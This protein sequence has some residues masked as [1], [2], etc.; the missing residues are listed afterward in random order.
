M[1][2]KSVIVSMLAMV[3]AGGSF[4]AAQMEFSAIQSISFTSSLVLF[5]CWVFAQTGTPV[6]MITES[7]AVGMIVSIALT[8]ALVVGFTDFLETGSLIPNRPIGFL[9][10][11]L[12][13][14]PYG[15]QTLVDLFE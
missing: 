14:I 13:F 8:I 11:L 9:V 1:T 6:G 7:S 3:A 2:T 12:A 15:Q 4:L 10:T 5:S